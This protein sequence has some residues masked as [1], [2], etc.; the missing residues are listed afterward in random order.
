MNGVRNG[1]ATFSVAAVFLHPY[2]VAT[3]LPE[4]RNFLP[5]TLE[6]PQ[7]VSHHSATKR[8]VLP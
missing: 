2:L 6:H 7:A 8:E 1:C 4:R 5:S 3:R